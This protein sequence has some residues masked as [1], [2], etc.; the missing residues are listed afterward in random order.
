MTEPVPDQVRTAYATALRHR[1][2][3]GIVLGVVAAVTGLI[4]VFFAVTNLAF[5]LGADEATGS[6]VNLE[7]SKNPDGSVRVPVRYSVVVE[8]TDTSGDTHR[9]TDPRA[10]GEPPPIGADVPV[11][12]RPDT[13]TDARIREPLVMYREA[14][15]F[16][17]WSILV[18]IVAEELIRRRHEL[19]D[20]SGTD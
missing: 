18:A 20:M 11:L 17:I 4:A 6:V 12:Y 13:P 9:F 8:F 14:I 2:S 16:G 3:V 5:Q 19:P 7:T 15:T 10:T 1:R